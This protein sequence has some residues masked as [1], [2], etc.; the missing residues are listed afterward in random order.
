MVQNENPL[1]L[2]N[3]INSFIL[4]IF[5]DH[6]SVAANHMIGYAAMTD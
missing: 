2:E 6:A 1:L 3:L 5:R 4:K